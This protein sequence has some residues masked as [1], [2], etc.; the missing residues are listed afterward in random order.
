MLSEPLRQALPGAEL[1]VTIDGKGAA[2]GA[3][4]VALRIRWRNRAGDW[5]APAALGLG[6]P[7]RE[8]RTMKNQRPVRRGYSLI[9]M[10]FVITVLSIMMGMTAMMIHG[11]M[12]ISK[13]S[14]SRLTE[15]ETLDRLGRQFRRDAHAATTAVSKPD[16][17]EFQGPDGTVTYGRA[18][19]KLSRAEQAPGGSM[20]TDFFRLPLRG[21]RRFEAAERDGQ[22]WVAL[23]FG[24]KTEVRTA[25][26][27]AL[28][29]RDQRGWTHAEVEK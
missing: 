16:V 25:R 2:A 4:R 11:L 17:I 21:A 13:A 24:P 27:D 10:L 23:I 22:R 8:V 9:E 12:R 19:G 18:G 14:Q 15:T 5:D 7:A 28:V 26:I 1:A 6:P 29:G 3:K 20:R